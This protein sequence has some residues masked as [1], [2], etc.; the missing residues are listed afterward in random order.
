MQARKTHEID[1]SVERLGVALEP[2]GDASEAEGTLNPACARSRDGQLLLYPRD[3]AHGNISRVGRVRS[4]ADGDRFSF[5]RDGFALEPSAVYELRPQPGY[6]CEDPRATFIPAL[7]QYVMAYTAFGPQG[8][9]I[10]LALSDDG[11]TWTRLGKLIFDKPGMHIGDD[12]DCA[13]FPEPVLSP[14]GVM[15]IAF[16][17]RPMLHLSAVDGRAAIPIIERMPYRDRESIR[18]GY[19][20]LEPALKDRQKLLDVCESQLL[21]A[22]NGDWGALKVGC[23]TPPVRI[24]EGWMSIFHGVDVIQDDAAK[25][26]MRY[27]AGIMIHDYKDVQT[28]IYRS[29]HPIL[30]PEDESELHGIVDNVVF[31]TGIDPRPDLGP[32]VFDFYYGMA[33]WS[34]GAG[35]MTLTA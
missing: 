7:D 15:S 12:K 22:P 21:L 29:A 10:A 5:Q 19:I 17:H 34:I 20:P 24:D 33:D 8:P 26:K 31:P 1:V 28:I 23:G 3:V 11:Y 27:S 14:A 18:M 35:R 9:R 30:T 4:T 2:N 6:G 13:F 16:Y 32:R 25:P